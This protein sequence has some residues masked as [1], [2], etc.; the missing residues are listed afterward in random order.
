VK[1]TCTNQGNHDDTP[2][3]T[4]TASHRAVRGAVL[5]YLGIP[6]AGFLPA[7]AVYLVSWRSSFAHRHA[8]EA[9]RGAFAAVLYFLCLLIIGTL[10]ALDSVV[11]AVII[12]GSLVLALW[13]T[14]V[15]SAARAASAARQ[16]QP[17][18][19]PGWLRV[20]ARR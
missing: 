19:F 20:A 8:A 7:L 16:G 3:G 14:M 4:G 13:L 10:L 1:S 9:L 17:Y 11:V 18:Q 2:G 15:V 12:A 6:I 5:A